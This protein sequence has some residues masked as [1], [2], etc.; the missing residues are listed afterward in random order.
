MDKQINKIDTRQQLFCN[1]CQCKKII[2]IYYNHGEEPYL[3]CQCDNCHTLIEF[4]LDSKL[5]INV[6]K[7]KEKLKPEY[8][9]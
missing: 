7:V 6:P 5:D 1:L 8:I 4:N 9:Q 2:I 3:L